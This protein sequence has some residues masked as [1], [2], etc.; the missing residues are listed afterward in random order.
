MSMT[1]LR[2]ATGLK[3]PLFLLLAAPA[4]V[5]A[6]RARRSKFA[7]LVPH[8]VF[9]HENFDVQLAVV[10]HKR[11]THEFWHDR[12]GAGPSF[13]RVLGAVSHAFHFLE[14]LGIYERT[15]FERSS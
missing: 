15:L 10:D 9:G 12:A 13:D 11:V 3:W 4:A 7:Q 1:S 8:H 2:S 14:Q 6:E 5:A